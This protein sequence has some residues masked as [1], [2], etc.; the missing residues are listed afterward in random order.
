MVNEARKRNIVTG[1]GRGSAGGSLVSYLL[2]IITIDPIKYDLI[3][4]RFLVPER[5]GLN[6]VDEITVMEDDV[7]VLSG[8]KVVHV[9]FSGKEMTFDK[10]ATFKIMRDGMAM[11]VY[12]DE[13]EKGDEILFDNRDILWNINRHNE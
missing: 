6:W 4:S 13:L 3:F 12:A 1:I 8:N 7:I 2:G 5:C 10:D 11:I 9:E